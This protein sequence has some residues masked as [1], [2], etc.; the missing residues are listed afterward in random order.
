MFAYIH[1]LGEKKVK[2][3]SNPQVSSNHI[4]IVVII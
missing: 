1:V 3:A 2:R 4:N